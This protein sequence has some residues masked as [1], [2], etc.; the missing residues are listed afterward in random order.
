[1]GIQKSQFVAWVITERFVTEKSITQEP[2]FPEAQEPTF[3]IDIRG[4][5][6]RVAL[7]GLKTRDYSVMP[8][9]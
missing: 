2:A 8:I 7:A 3:R 1:V 6:L 4:T 9:T 5:R